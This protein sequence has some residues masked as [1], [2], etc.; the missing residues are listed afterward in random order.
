MPEVNEQQTQ[1]NTKTLQQLIREKFDTG[2]G[3]QVLNLTVRGV[4]DENIEVLIAGRRYSVVGDTIFLLNGRSAN[5]EKIGGETAAGAVAGTQ[6]EQQGGS[7]EEAGANAGAGTEP[8]SAGESA[9]GETDPSLS[10]DVAG[11]ESGAG[12]QSE[13][14]G[15]ASISVESSGDSGTVSGVEGDG[16]IDIAN[17]PTVDPKF[18]DVMDHFGADDLRKVSENDQGD[19]VFE[20]LRDGEVIKTGTLAG[21]E[22][23]VVG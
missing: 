17:D 14:A 16:S 5:L 18:L 12:A 8:G 10:G 3:D 23:E 4:S 9:Q 13:N 20:L 15:D 22:A 1:E 21:L 11:E 2:E 7:S 6:S 19:D